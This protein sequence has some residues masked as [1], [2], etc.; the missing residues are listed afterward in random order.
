[1][2]KRR[3]RLLAEAEFRTSDFLPHR[4]DIGAAAPSW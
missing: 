3:G 2:I 4:H 1:M